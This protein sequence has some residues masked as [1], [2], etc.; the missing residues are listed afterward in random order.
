MRKLEN[1]PEEQRFAGARETQEEGDREREE[2]AHG[3][4]DM[5]GELQEARAKI[6]HDGVLRD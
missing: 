3:I 6:Q 4:F 1:V 2:G 5:T